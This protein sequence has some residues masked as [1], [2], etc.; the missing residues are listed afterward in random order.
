[1]A[2]FGWSDGNSYYVDLAENSTT[3]PENTLDLVGHIR[4]LEVMHKVSE[5]EINAISRPT[6]LFSHTD[7][8]K[9]L[10][11]SNVETD[12]PKKLQDNGATPPVNTHPSPP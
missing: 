5:K 8:L 6:V 9:I 4:K 12:P 1:M 3:S 11:L 2:S 10:D 7:E